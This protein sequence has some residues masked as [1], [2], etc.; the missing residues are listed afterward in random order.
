MTAIDIIRRLHEHR[1]WSI[2]RLVE[3]ARSLDQSQLHRS[4]PIGMGSVWATLVHLHAAEYEWLEAIDGQASGRMVTAD[5]L[6][7]WDDLNKLRIV[8]TYCWR[9]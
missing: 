9:I 4:F 7:L 2:S 3:S 6:P 1:R 5:D 8:G